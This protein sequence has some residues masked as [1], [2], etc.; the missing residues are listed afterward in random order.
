MNTVVTCPKCCSERVEI[1]TLK[2]D[3]VLL[4]GCKE[5]GAFW[6]AEL[7]ECP[8]AKACDNCA[9]R[10]GSPERSDPDRWAFLMSE[11]ERGAPFHCHKRVPAV[12][13]QHGYVFAFEIVEQDGRQV[14][15]N[16]PV[17]SG[18]LAWKLTQIYRPQSGGQFDRE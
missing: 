12:L 3:G 4:E 9:W 18:W 6:E 2:I 15:R 7:R 11:F 13:D 10:P 5:C 16:A 1:L 14:V 8:A 17:C